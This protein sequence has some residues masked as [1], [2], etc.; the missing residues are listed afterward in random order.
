MVGLEL[1][2]AIGTYDIIVGGDGVE[3]RSASF[4][5]NAYHK[6]TPEKKVDEY[7]LLPDPVL[8]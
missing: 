7:F 3:I 1:K 8:P 4:A 5:G 6:K 2:T